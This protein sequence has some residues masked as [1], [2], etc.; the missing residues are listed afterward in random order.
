[1]N[2]PPA[3]S[4]AEKV[5]IEHF[6]ADGVDMT[7]AWTLHSDR[8]ADGKRPQSVRWAARSL[9]RCTGRSTSQY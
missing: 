5:L 1:L 2:E 4:H 8:H 9:P 6:D 7:S 3:S